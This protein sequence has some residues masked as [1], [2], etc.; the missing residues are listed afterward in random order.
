MAAKELAE[1]LS[2]NV[3]ECGICLESFKQPRCL[4]CLHAFCH[5]CLET[6]C[7]GKN[8]ILCPVCQ[9]PTTVPEEGVSGFPVH[10][11]MN[12]IQETLDEKTT[13][14]HFEIYLH[15]VHKN[16]NNFCSKFQDKFCSPMNV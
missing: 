4:P 12:T 13:V 15:D 7:E 2:R 8:Q 16:V 3:L 9:K 14:G 6:F 1:R 11:I 5:D 10:F